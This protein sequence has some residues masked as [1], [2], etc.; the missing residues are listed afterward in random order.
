MRNRPALLVAALLVLVAAAAA[1]LIF[2]YWRDN[3]ST[4]FPWRAAMAGAPALH[5]WNPL[6]GGGQPL[7]GNPNALAFYP[8]WVLFALLPPLAA[9]N[10]HFLLHAILGA[11]A[12]RA[13]LR[14]WAIPPPWDLAGAALWVLSGAAVST[15]AFFNLAPA[16][17]LIPLALLGA[18]RV[19]AR[20]DLRAALLFGGAFGLLALAG[21][22]V[23]LLATAAV[24]AMVMAP[25][26]SGAGATPG[27]ALRAS[28]GAV[29][30]ALAIASPLLL[31]W[32]EIAGE[33]ERGVRPYSAE[34]A[35]AASLSPW[36]IVEMLAGPVRGL[37]TDL[38]RAGWRAS[39]AASRWP[40]F[41]LYLYVGAA[42]LPALAAPPRG[43]RRAQI[44]ALALLFVATGRFNPIVAAIAENV[45]ASRILRY[46]E[47]LAL[48]LTALL[49]ALIAG[50]L[51][52]ETRGTADRAAGAAGAAG[53][54]ILAIAAMARPHSW[55]AP[56]RERALLAAAVALPLFVLM[57]LPVRRAARRAIA[58]VT[59]GMA[60]VFALAAAPVDLARF[61][62]EPPTAARA[63]ERIVR[64]VSA[65]PEHGSARGAYRRA[66]A[67]AEPLWGAAFG[68]GYALEKSPDG[69][70]AYFSR[71]AHE[72]ARAADP[73]VA[74][75]WS[76]LAG[77]TAIVAERPLEAGELLPPR[78]VAG[79][80]RLFR[81]EVRSPLPHVHPVRVAATPSIGAAIALLEDPRTDVLRVAAGPPGAESGTLVGVRSAARIADGWR[82]AVDPATGGTLLVNEAYF[83]AWRAVDQ[84]GRAL[85]VVPLNVDRVGVAVPRGTTTIE[86]RFGGRRGLIAGAWIASSLLLVL[87]ALGGVLRDR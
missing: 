26:A 62:R 51:A 48:P 21:E 13:L 47:K 75:R 41:F 64:L 84:R 58:T 17:A 81:Q 16:L 70:Y 4:H 72:R 8:D 33:T 37:P 80:P 60:A 86:L 5:L 24:C 40:P 19:A 63:G 14:A 39:G 85:R 1:P 87:V 45:A 28:A 76:R 18:E 22:P 50:W 78:A 49:V 25:R 2:F 31:A 9:F 71:I 46:P 52:K 23:T 6:A 82:I 10:L 53:A 55:S 67:A 44:A 32:S 12:M 27:R 3:F 42:A 36:Q 61:Y 83:R 15:L 30:L 65:I 11:F 79:N 59:I 68:I 20:G 38:G 56:M 69:M 35:L 7:A 66:A 74:A 29:V 73:R 57:A 77:A 54:A 34:T 43:L